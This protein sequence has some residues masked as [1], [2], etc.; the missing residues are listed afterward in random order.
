MDS[1][2]RIIQ[3]LNRILKESQVLTDLEDRYV[4]SFEK[5][6]LDQTYSKPDI[7][8]RVSS[9]KEEKE[10]IELLEKENVILIK[11][12]EEASSFNDKTSKFLILLDNIKIPKLE[13]Y[14][15]KIGEKDDNIT[16]FN[17]LHIAGYGTYRNLALLVQNLLYGKTLNKCR[18]CITCSGYCTVSSS[19]NGVE[20][21]SSKGRM[22]ITKGIM[23]G[24]LNFSDKIVD[25]LYNCTKCGLC[26]AQCFPDLE[27]HEAILH[28]RHDM[29]EKSLVPQIFHRAA[30][31]IFE[32]GDPSATPVTHRL[33]R[34][35]NLSE[36]YLPEKSDTLCWLGCTVATRTPKT[37]EA[38]I[39][40]LNHVN[41]EF[42]M[43]G[44]QEGC[45][46]YVLIS[47]GLWEEATK[48]ANEVI[49]RIEKTEAMTLITPCSGCYYTFTRLYP[50]ILNLEM[51]C[52]I[53]HTSQY[54]E[55]L[56]REEKLKLKPL[57]LNVTYHD[58]CSL[59]RH[60]KV[61]EAPRNVLKA[62][63]DLNLIEMP[64][65][66]EFARCCG[67]GGGLW[68]YNNQV[69]KELA[70]TRLKED[71]I[72]TNVNILTTACPLCQLNFRFAS[73]M[74]FLSKNSI[75]IYDIIEIIESAM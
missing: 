61:Y 73:H 71:L 51:P 1:K 48:V 20:T 59:G 31:N 2:N 24:E 44:E 22:L 69:S 75:K 34:I 26:F 57:N 45:C 62:I 72:P 50:E 64:L 6:F 46:G 60:C 28:L 16:K 4:Y 5:I 32:N 58:P 9:L 30:N 41:V 74:N 67:G 38:F 12:G 36:L 17:E 25:I 23:N 14:S 68:T 42:T 27:F 52:E 55:K 39:N 33:T 70:Y 10:V 3:Q 13:N 7:I 65:N 35:K 18:Q 37:A 66:K 54:I 15:E 49:K 63:P 47:S 56:I 21:W 11:R 8:V 19:F 43:L 53:L 29:A 40:I